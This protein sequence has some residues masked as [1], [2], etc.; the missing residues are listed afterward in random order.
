MSLNLCYI[1]DA[2]SIHLQKWLDYFSKKQYNITLISPYNL[3]I[4]NIK[5]CVVPDL[6]F[7]IFYPLNIFLKTIKITQLLKRINPD[8]IHIHYLSNNGLSGV[9]FRNSKLI[10]TVWGSDI[11][12]ELKNAKISGITRK[13]ILNH[14][15]VIT[16]TSQFLLNATKSYL[17]QDNNIKL[18]PFGVDTEFFKPVKKKLNS[19]EITISFIKQLEKH[20][21]PQY[22]IEAYK[23]VHKQFPNT[24]LK[25]AGNGSQ[26]SHLIKLVKEYKLIESV[27]FLGHISR[28]EVKQLLQA[29]DI[30]VMPT[31]CPESFGVAALEAQ[32]MEV[33]VVASNIG[34]IPEAVS[35]KK[36]ALLTEP[37]NSVQ[38]AES[39]SKLSIDNKLR[40]AMGKAGRQ[41]VLNNY[42]WENCAKIMEDLYN[43]VL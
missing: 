19:K 9:N 30:F 6:N 8:I 24:K 12:T 15:D 31:V 25:I 42:Q 39:I 11:L 38:L 40:L 37:K 29:T 26:K 14:S 23:F 34:G 7:R 27:E 20:Y 43:S 18:I 3:I 2:R 4:D 22:L 35:N 36:S 1:G 10:T 33:P 41:F 32:A 17:H 16:A 13:Y 28:E 5:L 21:G